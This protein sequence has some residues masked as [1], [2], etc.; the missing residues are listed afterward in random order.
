MAMQVSSRQIRPSIAAA[1]AQWWRSWRGNR[2]GAAE[3]RD[4]GPEE[5]RR[6]ASD[7]GV[8]PEDVRP[9]AG[10]WPDSADLLTRRMTALQLDPT[11][12]AQLHPAVSNDLKR[13]CSLC[14]SKGRCEHDLVSG[15]TDSNW[16]EYC[17]NTTTLKALNAEHSAPTIQP[18][19]K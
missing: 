13:L 4:F 11:V 17:P 5:L 8:A 16:Q 18:A 14:V 10:K 7:I 19:N 15:A 1:I 6:L 9:L 2:A 3:L 12:I